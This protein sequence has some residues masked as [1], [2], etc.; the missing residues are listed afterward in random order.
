[1]RSKTE[2]LGA[3]NDPPSQTSQIGGSTTHGAAAPSMHTMTEIISNDCPVSVACMSVSGKMD[4]GI[5]RLY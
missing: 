5:R 4:S 3:G 2:G 1:M